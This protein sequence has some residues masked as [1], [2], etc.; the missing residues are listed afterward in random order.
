MKKK[1]KTKKKK[2]KFPK[3]NQKKNKRISNLNKALFHYLI[4]ELEKKAKYP[5]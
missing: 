5:K 3:R 2:T 4:N 1:Q